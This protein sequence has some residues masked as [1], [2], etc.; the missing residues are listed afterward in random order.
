MKSHQE[1]SDL[2]SSTA[3]DPVHS[4]RPYLPS[5]HFLG[6]S[7]EMVVLQTDAHALQTQVLLSHAICKYF[8]QSVI[9]LLLT[10]KF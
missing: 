2:L 1:R 10:G 7:V 8:S 4:L 3:N 5:G 9:F 6:G